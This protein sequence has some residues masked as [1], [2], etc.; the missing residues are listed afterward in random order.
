MKNHYIFAIATLCVLMFGCSEREEAPDLSGW[1]KGA[2]ASKMVHLD[3]NLYANMIKNAGGEV[4]RL[5]LT[6]GEDVILSVEIYGNGRAINVASAGRPGL[7]VHQG[8]SGIDVTRYL[9]LPD[10]A[11]KQIVYGVDG[12]IKEETTILEND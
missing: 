10:G 2:E 3:G 1:F 12:K 11:T 4:D 5:C 8:V 9:R 7:L 6:E